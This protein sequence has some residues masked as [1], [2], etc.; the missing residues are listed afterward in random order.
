MALKARRRSAFAMAA[1][2]LLLFATL[3]AL[4]LHGFSLAAWHEVTDGSATTGVL[5]G[6]PRM[7]RSDDWKMHL[8]LLIS[9]TAVTPRFPVVNPSVGLGQS[10]LLP[11]DALVAN[12]VSLFR[13]TMWGFLLGPDH[14]VAWLWWSRVLG[15]FGVWL[16]VLAVVTRGRLAPAATGAALL[17]CAPFFQF[18]SFNSAPQVTSMGA[19]FLA[20]VALA[21]ARTTAAIAASAIA[22]A[23]S[24]AW[25]ALSIYPPYQVTLAW[26]Y[27]ALVAG[28]LLDARDELP[29]RN[30]VAL[31]AVALAAAGAIAIAIVAAF[32]SEASDAIATMRDTAYPGRRL[33]TGAERNL[34]ELWNANLGAPLWAEKWGPLFNICEA[35]SFWMLSPVPLAL[36]LW[37]RKRGE[38]IDALSAAVALYAIALTLYA[39]VGVPAFVAQITALGFVP[40]KRA[41]IGIGIA[42]AILLVR[43]AACAA[44]AQSE[45]RTRVFAIALGWFVV[46]AGCAVWLARE[47]PD[48]QLPVLLAF[49]LA[50]AALA[51]FFL[52]QPR[53]ALL[54]LVAL[55][56]ISTLWFNPLA[57]GGAQYLR[58][59]ALAQK[60]TEIDRAEGGDTTWVSFGRDDLPN[61]FRAIG[62][63]ALNGVHP[64]PQLALWKRI[65]PAGRF[66]SVY[67][68]Y[69]HIAFVAT[70][71][72]EPRF[73][74]HSQDYVIV[75]IRPNSDAFRALGV[76]HVLIR[77]PDAPAFE[78]LSGFEPIA[79]IGPNHLY[80]VGR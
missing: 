7:I 48:A 29:L 4:R 70:P 42:D 80:R 39:L 6:E 14:G 47:L 58:D 26:L 68:R 16:A 61:L 67:N 69:A 22:L 28:W 43:F 23:L 59:N 41:V 11:V 74:L 45:E 75:E 56:A 21:R 13:P 55:S 77:D 51:A 66:R 71:S 53:R 31:R 2:L 15:L 64:I 62:V 19:A 76:T 44:P 20:T 38:R 52:L 72:G 5:L 32:A 78:K 57:V 34:A 1:T 35:A 12:W 3:V 8:P 46:L 24:G 18:W 54:A 30:H 63:Q 50:N 36:L 49:A 40:G 10:M 60:I 27:I 73:R 33:S 37:R 79:T 65:D 17:V 25:F 9:Q